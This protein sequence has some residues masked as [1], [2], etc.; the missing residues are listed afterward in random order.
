MI[1]G[2]YHPTVYIEFYCEQGK[3]AATNVN[4][5]N[6]VAGV[7]N[8]VISVNTS[9]NMSSDCPTFQIILVAR[10]DWYT[11]VASNDLLIIYMQR[12]PLDPQKE[13]VI[14]GVVDDIRQSMDF[15][16]GQPQRSVTI[17]GRGLGKALVNFQIGN[18]FKVTNLSHGIFEKLTS[19]V[20]Q[21][22][23]N[24]IKIV[25]ESYIG[26]GI[27]YTWGTGDNQRKLSDMV[28]YP[29]EPNLAHHA[30]EKQLAPTAYMSYEGNLWNLIKEF[31]NFPW[32]E[33]YWECYGGKANLIHRRTPFNPDDWKLLQQEPTFCTVSDEAIVSDNTG[34][35]DMETYTIFIVESNNNHLTDRGAFPPQWFP[36]FYY[37]YGV[38]ELN[39]KTSFQVMTDAM[40]GSFKKFIRELAN[41]NCK[42]NVFE[43]GTIVVLGLAMFKVGEILYVKSRNMEYYIESVSHNFQCYGVWTTTLGVTRGIEPEKR[44]TAPW[45]TSI[46]FTINSNYAIYLLTKGQ[47][48][49]DLKNPPKAPSGWLTP[50]NTSSSSGKGGKRIT[51]GKLQWPTEEGAPITGTY[52]EPRGE[53]ENGLPAH[54]HAGIDIGVSEGTPIYAAEAGEVVE[55]DW[56]GDDGYGHF[57]AIDHGAGFL[58]DGCHLYTAYGH[59]SE[60]QVNAGDTVSRGQVIGLS[61]HT[62]AGSAEHLHFNVATSSSYYNYPPK[63]DCVDPEPWFSDYTVSDLVSLGGDGTSDENAQLIYKGLTENCGFSRAAALG[64]MANMYVEAGFNTQAVGDSGKA[65]GLCQWRDERRNNLESSYQS[66]WEIGSQLAFMMDELNDSESNAYEHLQYVTDDASGAYTAGANFCRY[67]E[68]PNDIDGESDKRGSI[69]AEYYNSGAWS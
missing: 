29:E 23:F 43:S 21:D 4:A 46:D 12:P 51:S 10:N 20:G 53:G 37:K 27:Q 32:N 58:T 13:A 8:D 68:R 30:D 38:S 2:V 40:K 48:G 31:S 47:E 67:Y 61:G 35:S 22:S 65:Y 36:D 66:Y 6:Q 50:R 5:P 18:V 25:W 7:D 28:A 33:T 54:F 19:I 59:L 55:S 62:G 44:F 57:I 63:G 49:I 45:D 60:R 24:A 52:G 56:Q 17:T 11:N 15:S 34:R 69:A 1:N 26:R 41:F 3:L 9:R 16:S 39:V 64:I 14:V 42:N